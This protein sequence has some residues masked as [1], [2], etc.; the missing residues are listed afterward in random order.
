MQEFGIFV[1]NHWLLFIALVVVLVMLVMTTVQSR[2]LGYEELKPLDLVQMINRVEPLLLDVR[3]DDEF[4]GGHLASAR[5]IPLEQ[6]A[7]RQEEL[8]A[9]RDRPIVVYCRSG[10][11]S[12]R[13]AT[14]L[15]K[16]GFARLY[17]LA[18]GMLA[19]QNS[20]LPVTR[21]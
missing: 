11:R 1:I 21:S 6:L 4:S 5:H 13:A 10:Q 9:Y 3:N 17:K 12:A 18:G 20:S 16:K 15:K 8:Q 14:L 2:L 7:E 19:W